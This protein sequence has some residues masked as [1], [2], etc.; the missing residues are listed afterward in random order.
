MSRKEDCWINAV[1]ESFLTTREHVFL[2]H[3]VRRSHIEANVTLTDIIEP[4]YNRERKHSML[5]YVRVQPGY[6]V[7]RLVR[8]HGLHSF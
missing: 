8:Q 7:D 4:C 1:V 6:M 3:T 5:D 2:A